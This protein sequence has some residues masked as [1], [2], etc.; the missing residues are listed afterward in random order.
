MA[1]RGDRARHGEFHPQFGFYSAITNAYHRKLESIGLLQPEVSAAGKA[2]E[3]ARMNDR[4]FKTN[5]QFEQMI[6]LR[7]SGRPEDVAKFEQI[8]AGKNRMNLAEYEQA[9]AAADGA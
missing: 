8:V 1:L 7:D 9:K 2:A 4:S 5:P 6:K 3:W